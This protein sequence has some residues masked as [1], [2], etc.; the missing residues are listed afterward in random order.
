MPTNDESKRPGLF[1]R[2]KTLPVNV[3]ALS[4]VAFLNDASS[5]II[6]PLLPAF[7]ALSLGATPFAIGMIEGF[8]ESVAKAELE[9]LSQCCLCVFHTQILAQV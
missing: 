7:L 6:Y 3:F 9:L 4:F 8:A 1:A 5:E 2:Y